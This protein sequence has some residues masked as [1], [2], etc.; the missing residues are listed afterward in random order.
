MLLQRRRLERL[1]LRPIHAHQQHTRHKRPKDLT[2]DI[3]RDFLP[4]ETLPDGKT[5]GDGRVEMP[6]GGGRAGNDGK[7]DA[8]GEGPTDLEEGAKCGGAEGAGG[9][10]GKG[11]YGG[12]TRESGE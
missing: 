12:D 2:D 7:G 1:N 3:M 6:T 8:D 4:W 11:G 5:E 9:V 10:D